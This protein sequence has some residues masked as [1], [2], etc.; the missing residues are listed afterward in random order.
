[1]PVYPAPITPLPNVSDAWTTAAAQILSTTGN[2]EGCCLALG[3]GSG[4]LIEELVKQTA[5]LHVVAMDPDPAKVAAL[6]LKMDAAGLY[7]SRC[8]AMV[9]NPVSGGLPPYVGRLIVSED[10]QAAGFGLGQA[11]VEK[12]FNSIRPYGGAMWLP[13]SAA[14]HSALSGWVTAAGLSN[15]EVTRQ[16]SFTQLKR[17]GALPGAVNY[18]ANSFVSRDAAI[19][20]PLGM[21]WFD[22]YSSIA[23]LGIVDGKI[24]S[25]KDVYTGLPVTYSTSPSYT[26]TN[27]VANGG[28][29]RNP[30][31]GTSESRYTG[32]QA[33]AGCAGMRVY[34]NMQAGR[35]GSVSFI[36]FI[37]DSGMTHLTWGRTGCN[38][39]ANNIAPGNGVLIGFASTCGCDW[40]LASSFGMVHRPDEESWSTWTSERSRRTLESEPVRS[41]G[42]N[43][44][45]P[46]ERMDDGTLW[47]HRPRRSVGTPTFEVRVNGVD[48]RCV[49]PSDQAVDFKNRSGASNYYHHASRI[50]GGTSKSWV[51]A[52]GIIGATN[53]VIGLTPE[54]VVAKSIASAPV[55]DGVL[56]DACWDGSSPLYMT[57]FIDWWTYTFTGEVG[58]SAYLR[59]DSSNLY[60][61]CKAPNPRNEQ[62]ISLASW[63]VCITDPSMLS[64]PLILTVNASGVQSAEKK[65]SGSWGGAWQSGTTC[66]TNGGMT[67][68][69][70]IPFASLTAAGLKTT[71]LV[72]NIMFNGGY[73][74]ARP[75][76]GASGLRTYSGG[77]EASSYFA[78]LSFDQAYGALKDTRGY[79]VKLHFAETEGAVAGQRVFDVKLQGQTVLSNFDIFTAAG[80]ANM[81]IV[82]AFSVAARDQL[83]VELVPVTGRPVIS[84]IELAEGTI[85][86]G[87]DAYGIP[88]SWKIEY[89]GSVAVPGS[90]ALED[91]DHDGMNN[92][93][94]YV[95][96][97][98]PVNPLSRFQVIALRS[99]RGGGEAGFSVAFQTVIGRIYGVTYKSNLLES[100]WH[101]LTNN[102]PGT[103]GQVTITD[104][105]KP[106]VRFYRVG[107]RLP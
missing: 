9:G 42:V 101:D 5:I 93:Q 88:N 33:Y 24:G 44:G 41:M 15:A 46:S 18:Q 71:N 64:Y 22:D 47:L 100:V 13:T 26:T 20:A 40:P 78:P 79:L 65:W 107:V 66:S 92:L 34:G 30:F 4:R 74:G 73:D 57:D 62:N 10:I 102:V 19:R 97:T 6:R 98:S 95:A 69:Y 54:A 56:D 1:P 106:A 49:E 80:G 29:H 32:S 76:W 84:G 72:F 61:A 86:P 105:N 81:G 50:V 87:V 99:E 75:V 21:Q 60:V 103:G 16:G 14:E 28:T 82:K 3:I 59:Y 37:S 63:I 94:E 90:G 85:D 12:I 83:K 104:T 8:V 27:S 39:G 43:F 70:A 17:V 38:N 58:A 52:S 48:S 89:F 31:Y 96:G 77:V 23:Q 67:V 25:N 36:D 2:N 55:L 53:I 91:P 7:G 51:A 11:F 35:D 68:E 45:A